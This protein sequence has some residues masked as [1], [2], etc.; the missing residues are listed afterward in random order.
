MLG[1]DAVSVVW[2]GDIWGSFAA[3]AFGVNQFKAGGNKL[4]LI[5]TSQHGVVS[6]KT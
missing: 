4:L 3:S 6:P 2:K 5:T 1:S